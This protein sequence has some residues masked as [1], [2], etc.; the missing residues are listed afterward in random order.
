VGR[1]YAELVSATRRIAGT[2]IHASWDSEPVTEDADVHAPPFDF[3][4]LVRYDDA[5]LRA[6]VQHLDWKPWARSAANVKRPEP[7]AERSEA[8]R[9]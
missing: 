3:A 6:V 4:E 1:R 8:K 5:Y 7:A 9:E 2:A